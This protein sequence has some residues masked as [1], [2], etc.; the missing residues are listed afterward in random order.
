MFAPARREA[1]K[2]TEAYRRC[3]QADLR[4]QS[5]HSEVGQ[6]ERSL[7][8]S[9]PATPCATFYGGAQLAE[10]DASLQSADGVIYREVVEGRHDFIQYLFPLRTPGVNPR[11]PLLTSAD[12]TAMRESSVVQHR[13]W[14]MLEMML[15]FYGVE[16]TLVE[17]SSSDADT[18]TIRKRERDSGEEEGPERVQ[19]SSFTSMASLEVPSE[20][21]RVATVVG[22]RRWSDATACASAQRNLASNS[23]NNLRLTRILLFLGEMR[24]EPLKAALLRHFIHEVALASAYYGPGRAAPRQRHGSRSTATVYAPLH[25]CLGSLRDFWVE[26]M[27]DIHSRDELLQEL[28]VKLSS[29]PSAVGVQRLTWEAEM[30]VPRSLLLLRTPRVVSNPQE[31][32]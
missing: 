6:G 10:L 15:T 14:R 20:S 18:M 30:V 27:V 17:S 11:A 22:V 23:H 13:V 31:D 2:I 16:L 12:A 4:A 1:L 19:A 21:P 26:T 9:P 28:K 7:L 24:W 5:C 29:C 8:S 3:I 25:H 32:H